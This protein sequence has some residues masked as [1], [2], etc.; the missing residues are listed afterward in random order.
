IEIDAIWHDL[1]GGAAGELILKVKGRET[2][3][4]QFH[5]GVARADFWQLCGAAL[6]AGDYLALADAVRVLILENVP[7][8]GRS[9]YNEAKRFVILIDA[10][11][12]AKV[13]LVISAAD[14]PE[15][16]YVE[17]TG[18]FEFERTA[19]R[20]REMQSIGWGKTGG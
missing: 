5:N 2:V 8:L 11:Y 6:G 18:S 7:R 13:Q 12:E 10:L 3:L 17:G 16:L 4:R 1:T 14:L 19:S 15:R 9:N 20:L